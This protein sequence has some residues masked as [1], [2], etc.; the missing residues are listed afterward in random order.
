[1]VMVTIYSS[2]AHYGPL[3]PAAPLRYDMRNVTNPPRQ[4]R[5]NMDGRSKKL[6]DHLMNDVDF[7]TLLQAI[8][9]DILQEVEELQKQECGKEEDSVGMDKDVNATQ[10]IQQG[11]AE[12]EQMDSLALD[13]KLNDKEHLVSDEDDIEDN[14]SIGCSRENLDNENE[15]IVLVNCFCHLGRHRSA[16]MAEELARLKWPPGINIEVVHRDIDKDRRKPGKQ[17]RVAKSSR[18]LQNN[19]FD[20]D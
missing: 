6:R 4:L 13:P 7:V 12:P 18:M 11:R 19:E 5:G 14:I 8:Q 10:E 17:K 1:M 16:S 9:T 15:P 3:K 20:D 2:G